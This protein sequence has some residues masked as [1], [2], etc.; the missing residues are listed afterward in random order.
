MVPHTHTHTHTYGWMVELQIDCYTKA[1]LEVQGIDPC[2][3][4]MQSQ[5][6]TI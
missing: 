6:S 3:S 2:T 5:R 4:D 1:V